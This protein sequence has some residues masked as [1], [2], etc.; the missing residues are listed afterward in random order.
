MHIIFLGEWICKGICALS[1]IKCACKINCI[2][3]NDDYHG[4][5]IMATYMHT[6]ISS[7]GL[8]QLNIDV[9]L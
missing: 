3:I 2:L 8:R 5:Y 7:Q 1:L 6:I 9:T 4:P